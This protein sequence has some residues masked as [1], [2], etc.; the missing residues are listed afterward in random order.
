M[1]ILMVTPRYLP[2]MGGIETHVH[3]VSKRLGDSGHR[4]DILTTD[5]AGTLP[6]QEVVSDG[7]QVQR[8][9]AWPKE[10]DYYV[11]PIIYQQIMRT[12][13]D[14][15]H[16]QGYHTFVAPLGMLAA[17]RKPAPFVLTFHSGGH[18]SPLRNALR[19]PQ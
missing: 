7:V 4:V 16:I 12:Q 1:R 18:S 8:V 15:V 17:I 13:C 3:E 11:A 19:T 14:V 2:D 10:S 5:R 9:R 6:N